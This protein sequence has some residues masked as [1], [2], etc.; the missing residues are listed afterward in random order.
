MAILQNRNASTE[1][2]ELSMLRE[3]AMD[4]VNRNAPVKAV[5]TFSRAACLAH[6]RALADL[7]WPGI[8]IAE[9]HGGAGLGFVAL[10]AVLSALGTQLLAV[11]LLTHTLF[12]RALQRAAS[13]RRQMDMLAQVASG[14]RIGTVAFVSETA[15]QVGPCGADPAGSG[16]RL[17]GEQRFV[18]NG[19]VADCILV[20]IGGTRPEL[21]LVEREQVKVQPLNM[22][23]GRDYA[24]L[25]L[26]EV[27]LAADARLD[28]NAGLPEEL[29]DCARAGIAAE[30]I[31]ACEHA[32]QIT[33][34]YLKVRE[35]FGR[36]IG[37]FQALQHRAAKIVVDLE[38]AR[39]CV[40]AA[41]Q[42]IDESSA[43]V[44]ELTALAKY[45]AGA[46][47]HR[48]S[49]EIVQMHGGIGMTDEH[50][51]GR[52][53]KWARVSEMLYGNSDALAERYARAHGY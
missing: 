35:Q 27:T 14:A 17:R 20:C 30:M 34:D 52:Y 24:H 32:L 50:V 7:G 11:P 21:F 41:L 18:L 22:I 5:H 4:W 26:D 33:V 10:G 29:L 3:S 13:N 9:E 25:S 49:N 37:S 42:A 39:S 28:A 51:A 12:A 1:S 15:G 16:W 23:D 6:W 19:R 44:G 8:A 36:K 40:D 48:V 43:T 31:G 45:M 46:A 53:L 38:L 2:S 47:I